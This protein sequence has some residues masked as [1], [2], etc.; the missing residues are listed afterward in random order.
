MANSDVRSF[1][2]GAYEKKL[3]VKGWRTL[4]LNI[5]FFLFF[6]KTFLAT[7]HSIWDFSFLTRDGTNAPC[8]GSSVQSVTQLCPTLCHPMDCSQSSL[9]ITNP[10]SLLKL[11]SVESVRLLSLL[12]L[13]QL[14]LFLP[15]TFQLSGSF[16]MSQFFASCGQI[17]EV[18]LQ[19][20]SFQ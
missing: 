6:F 18:Q 1:S 14:L 17:L 15:S 3:N 20:H 16:T 8:L 11:T 10:W 7:S 9:S 2:L 19:H 12:I 5:Y 13:C 4:F